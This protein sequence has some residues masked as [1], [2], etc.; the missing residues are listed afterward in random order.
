MGW[1]GE[2]KGVIF[3]IFAEKNVKRVHVPAEH[4]TIISSAAGGRGVVTVLIPPGR[5]NDTLRG[6]INT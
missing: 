3:F 2:K 6:G 1:G 5:G 4:T